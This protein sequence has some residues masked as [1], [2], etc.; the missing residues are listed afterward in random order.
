MGIRMLTL[1]TKGLCH[2][3]SRIGG[4]KHTLSH[5]S[6]RTFHLLE[7]TTIIKSGVRSLFF[8]RSTLQH[9]VRGPSWHG[10]VTDRRDKNFSNANKTHS[11]PS[12]L[13]IRQ[14]GT[15][16]GSIW[17]KIYYLLVGKRNSRSLPQELEI[18]QCFL[19]D[20]LFSGNNLLFCCVFQ[21]R[22]KILLNVF[23]NNNFIECF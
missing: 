9:T 12:C 5:P 10:L 15:S 20:S 18:P 17:G 14:C 22:V 13:H 23:K 11:H 7:L 16:L 21:D 2:S 6:F 3:T 4:S 8:W 19:D 1:D